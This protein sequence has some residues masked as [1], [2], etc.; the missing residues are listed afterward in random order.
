MAAPVVA[1]RL[2]LVLG[3]AREVLQHLFDILVGPL[4]ALQRRVGLVDVGLVVLVVVHPHRRLVDVRLEG[5]VVVGKVGNR[6]S[7][8][9]VPPFIGSG[10]GS[11]TSRRY[12]GNVPAG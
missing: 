1:N 7:H 8:L 3:Q 12:R 2:L 5:V 6:V 9:A 10:G 4:G 11:L